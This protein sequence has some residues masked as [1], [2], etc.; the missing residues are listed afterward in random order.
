MS[1]QLNRSRSRVTCLL[2]R[3]Q[4]AWR[5]Q[6][7]WHCAS[8]HVQPGMNSNTAMVSTTSVEPTSTAQIT[9]N[10]KGFP[11]NRFKRNTRRNK[12]INP[13]HL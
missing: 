6:Q 13:D 5:K 12:L 3:T 2:G 4:Q 10:I 8:P 1:E 9:Q 11:M 7:L